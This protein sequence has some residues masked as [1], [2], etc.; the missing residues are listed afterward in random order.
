MSQFYTLNADTIRILK[1]ARSPAEHPSATGSNGGA[2]SSKL[3]Q[4]AKAA[5][6]DF[7]MFSAKK[8]SGKR[9]SGHSAPAAAEPKAKGK[10]K[11]TDMD[12]SK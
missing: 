10:R 9:G 12:T 3:S 8:R 5:E 7:N 6:D 11:A 1:E 4:P 2:S